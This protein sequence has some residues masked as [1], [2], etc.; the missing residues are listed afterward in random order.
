MKSDFITCQAACQESI[1]KSHINISEHIPKVFF[2][3]TLAYTGL[4]IF[5]VRK[6]FRSDE[7]NKK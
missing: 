6:Y 3:D 5:A 7:N 4:Q 1:S 2:K